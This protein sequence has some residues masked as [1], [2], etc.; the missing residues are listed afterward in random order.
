MTTAVAYPTPHRMLP[1]HMRW[2]TVL[3]TGSVLFDAVLTALL[4]TQDILYVP[5]L[6]LIGA[7]VVAVTFTTFLGG[8]PRRSEL[9]FAQI[10]TSAASAV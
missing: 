2:I 9:S 8:L 4:N 1:L 3:V 7:A 5:S 10:A 6:L